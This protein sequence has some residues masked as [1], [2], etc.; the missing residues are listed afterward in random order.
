MQGN[1]HVH[2]HEHGNTDIGARKLKMSQTASPT[3]TSHFSPVTVVL[4]KTYEYAKR[5]GLIDN[6]FVRPVFVRSYFLYKRFFEDP[7]EKLI[8]KHPNYF[9][10]IVLDIGANIGYTA[11]VFA[12]R[13]PLVIAFEPDV[14]NFTTLK[15][16]LA[17]YGMTERVETVNSAVGEKDGEIK[18]WRNEAHH[19]DHRVL[20]SEFESEVKDFSTVITVPL[21]AIDSFLETRSLSKPVTFI[22]IDVQGYELPVLRGM[23][24]TL[25][26]Y[27]SAP[28]AFEYAP[29]QLV[30]LGYAP[31]SCVNFFRERGYTISLLSRS[32]ELI[33][34]DDA[35]LKQESEKRGYIDLLATKA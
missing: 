9:Q 29:K 19:A 25:E 28:I 32:G 31:E 7:F 17:V 16:T 34:C 22:K 5:L 8:S 2:E 3:D 4:L 1:E 6:K 27:P 15:E 10:G 33:P 26:R 11:T 23:V 14:E 30:E 13:S 35:R 18:L 20:T 12:K 21:V 24:R